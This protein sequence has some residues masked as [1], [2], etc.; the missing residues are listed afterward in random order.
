[1]HPSRVTRRLLAASTALAAAAAVA[2]PAHTDSASTAETALDPVAATTS[3][4][5]T[6]RH[7]AG[8]GF[9]QC[10]APTQKAMDAWL[11]HSPFWAVGIYISGNSRAC[12]SQPNLTPTWIATQL[13][14]G[15]RIL[16]LTLGPQAYCNPRFP[17]YKD[18]P[19]IRRSKVNGFAAA[20][21]QG[22]A[23]AVTAVTAARN[24]GIA[25]RSTLWYDL[26][27]FDIRNVGCRESALSFLSG[28][29]ERI[30]ELGYRSGVY[31]S[32]ASGIKAID[33]ARAGRKAGF[34]PPNQLWIADW[35]GRP[36]AVG[37]W[38]RDDGW[39]RARVHQYRGGHNETWGGVTINIDSN[40]LN[41]G[42]G[43]LP[44]RVRTHCGGVRVDF[45]LY[46]RLVPGTRQVLRIK[47]TQCLLAERGFYAGTI[48]GVYDAATQAAVS[49]FRQSVGRAPSTTLNRPT[50]MALLTRGP[51]PLVKLGAGSDA[52]RR[53]QRALNA[54][55]V[56]PRLAITGS[57][58]HATMDAVKAYQRRVGLAATGV[59]SA[60][61]WE[62]LRGGRS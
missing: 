41:L 30:R 29:T 55:A 52:V 51:A 15:W 60:R 7:F 21:T 32:G 25:P 14:K 17:R 22:R 40:W 18:D 24:L 62:A 2:L 54:S 28:W 53:L 37:R 45:L 3:N 13:R 38:V 16:P 42:R 33:D 58:E 50:W 49:R 1:M 35:N 48:S 23:E 61:T 56:Q 5:V 8:Y 26:E 6:P 59:A 47:A 46:R 19:L 27:A 11:E 31:S 12:R 57:F 36:G 10:V 39:S 44:A 9:D 20:R 43:S 34:L 4:P